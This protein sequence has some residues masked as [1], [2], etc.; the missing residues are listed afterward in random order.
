MILWE[1]L[2]KIM[3][4]LGFKDASNVATDIFNPSKFL[5][6]L[7]RENTR[8]AVQ[9]FFRG[10]KDTVLNGFAKLLQATQQ[11]QKAA[12]ATP[13]GQ[14]LLLP[15]GVGGGFAALKTATFSAGSELE[16]PIAV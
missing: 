10:D 6:F 16:L 9:V 8:K 7:R 2:L 15:A 3:M 12:V 13:T 11:A 14:S 4:R 1:I 5:S